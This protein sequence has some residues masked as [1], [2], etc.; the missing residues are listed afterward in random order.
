MHSIL[1]RSLLPFACAAAAFGC[2]DLNVPPK[3]AVSA[4]G[5]FSDEQA[6][7]A[8]IARIYAGLAVT[9]QQGP[10]GSGDIAGIDEGFSHYL[11]LLW[12]MNELP[13]DEAAIAWNDAGVQPLNTQLW[14]SNNPFLTAMY[15]RVY[16]QVGLVNDFLRQ[17][18][19]ARLN[20]RNVS[21]ATRTRIQTYRAEA[22]FLRA[23]SYWHGIDFFG[24][25]PLVRE[26]DPLNA[27]PPAQATRSEVFNFIVSELNAVIPDLPALDAADVGR[28][29]QGAARML[30]AKVLMQANAYGLGARWNDAAT[31]LTPLLAGPYR[32]DTDYRRMFSGDNNTSPELIFQVV[33]D[34]VRT[35]SF[36]GTTFLMNASV[37]GFRA[38]SLRSAQG[39]LEAWWG[40]RL[41][42][43]MVAL[44]PVIGPTSPDVRSSFWFA[45]APEQ[46]TSMA[47]LTDFSN[48]TI[49]LKYRNRPSGPTG[50][51]ATQFS[52]IDYPMFRLGDA[53]LMYAE[54]ALRGAAGTTRAQALTYV[55]ALRER[56][57]GNATGNITDAQLTLDFIL[58]ERARELQWEGHR[59]VD[60]IRFGRF[61][62]QG[63]WA[64]KGNVVGGRTTEAFRNLYPKPASELS[65]NPNLTQNTGY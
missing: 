28:A 27:A 61:S 47:N 41:K 10:A 26:G 17:T 34:A 40:L 16:F 31:A 32:L 43:Q 7:R 33:Q 4:E 51:E 63:I 5:S 2:T 24:D 62:D 19:E 23:L 65:A 45:R 42:P 44:F 39:Q 36:G 29:D 50:G 20:E 25:I 8:Y 58:D 57:Y 37:G 35:Q 18:S 49:N 9:G 54:L 59:R 3:S 60:L 12:Q 56:A 52:N 53:Y 55:N 30:L 1:R 46:T 13:T 6:Y 14:P 64:W 21:A 11:R 15:Y 48:G 38:D 22:R